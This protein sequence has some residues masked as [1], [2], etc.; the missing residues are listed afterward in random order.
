MAGKLISAYLRWGGSTVHE[1]VLANAGSP[2]YR[3]PPGKGQT[4]QLPVALEASPHTLIRV[5]WTAVLTCRV[6]HSCIYFLPINLNQGISI[7]DT[8]PISYFTYT[9][10]YKPP[11]QRRFFYASVSLLKKFA[12]FGSKASSSEKVHNNS[13]AYTSAYNEEGSILTPWLETLLRK[14]ILLS[15]KGKTENRMTWPDIVGSSG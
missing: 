8:R 7:Y 6:A 13:A 5:K 12:H 1:E 4:F 2:T 15:V 11:F 3:L 14:C 9:V 10:K